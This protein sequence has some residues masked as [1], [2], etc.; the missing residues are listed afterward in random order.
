MKRAYKLEGKLCGNCAAKIQ[1]KIEKLDG[2]TKASVN[3]MTMRFT[4]EADD[5]KHAALLDESKKVFEDIEPTCTVK[6]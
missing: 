6:A 4:L 1:D 3:F 2:V 5:D